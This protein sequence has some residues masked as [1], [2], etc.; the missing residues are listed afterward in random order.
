MQA[1]CCTG[2]QN[3]ERAHIFKAWQPLSR[4]GAKINGVKDDDEN[5]E[6]YGDGDD[7]NIR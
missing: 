4:T 6:D 2:Y 7:K 5:E 1:R 3:R